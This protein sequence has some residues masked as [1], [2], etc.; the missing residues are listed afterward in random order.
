MLFQAAALFVRELA[1]LRMQDAG[2]DP[3]SAGHLSALVGFVVLAMLVSPILCENKA[4]VARMFHPPA[5][6][7]R[8]L[9]GSI[10]IGLALRATSWCLLIAAVAFGIREI[11]DTATA[12]GPFFWWQCPP[13][14]YLLLSVAVMAILTPI[15][16]ETMSR[17]L[18]LGSLRQRQVKGAVIISAALFAVLHTVD[19]L[20]ISFIFGIVT[21]IQMTNARTLWAPIVSHATFNGMIAID[22]DCLNGVWSPASTSLLL[23]TFAAILAMVF[24]FVAIWV[25]RSKMPGPVE[26]PGTVPG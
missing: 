25:A 17:G 5:A 2:I 4:C 16:E 11:P 15:F 10:C 21:A 13:A 14:S 8:V 24:T 26:G 3:Q 23:G 6:W 18:I 1:R 9:F 20:A 19:N 12:A 7:R 22:W